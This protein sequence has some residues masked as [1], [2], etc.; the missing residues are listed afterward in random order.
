MKRTEPNGIQDLVNDVKRRQK[1]IL[2][3]D[4]IAHDR[5]VNKILWNGPSGTSRVQR[6]G[7]L[8]IGTVLFL[9]GFAAASLSYEHQAWLGIVPSV[10]IAGGGLR[11]IFKSMIKKKL[12]KE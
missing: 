5:D 10:A 11:I 8:V 12:R 3:P 9:S 2:P 6:V 4:V 1:N 7:A